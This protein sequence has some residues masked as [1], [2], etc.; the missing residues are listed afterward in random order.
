[1]SHIDSIYSFGKRLEPHWLAL[2]E[3]IKTQLFSTDTPHFK[4]TGGL[5]T[6]GRQPNLTDRLNDAIARADSTLFSRFL[7][8]NKAG[9]THAPSLHDSTVIFTDGILPTK[10]DP[11]FLFPLLKALDIPYPS[12]APAWWASTKGCERAFHEP[13]SPLHKL[14]DAAIL[15]AQLNP[16]AWNNIILW[17]VAPVAFPTRINTSGAEYAFPQALASIDAACEGRIS[18]GSMH[19]SIDD[20]NPFSTSPP[21][22]GTFECNPLTY[23]AQALLDLLAQNEMSFD[24]RLEQLIEQGRNRTEAVRYLQEEIPYDAFLKKE[25]SAWYYAS[26]IDKLG[27]PP[28]LFAPKGSSTY[29]IMKRALKLHT[30]KQNIPAK[31]AKHRP[32]RRLNLIGYEDCGPLD[33]SKKSIHGILE[34][35][36]LDALN[37]YVVNKHFARTGKTPRIHANVLNKE[38]I[39]F[40]LQPCPYAPVWCEAVY[41]QTCA[42]DSGETT[43]C[44]RDLFDAMRDPTFFEEAGLGP[45]WIEAYNKQHPPINNIAELV[46]RRCK[47]HQFLFYSAEH[48][49]WLLNRAEEFEVY[50]SADFVDRSKLREDDSRRRKGRL[51]WQYEKG[52][53]VIF[54]LIHEPYPPESAFCRISALGVSC[55]IARTLTMRPDAPPHMHASV[56]AAFGTAGHF[57]M[58]GTTREELMLQELLWSSLGMEPLSRAEYTEHAITLETNGTHWSGHSDCPLLKGPEPLPPHELPGKTLDLVIVDYKTSV[59]TFS[60]RK[61]YILQLGAYALSYAQRHPETRFKNFYLAV[62]NRPFISE[63][64]HGPFTQKITI[65]K[66]ENKPSDLLYEELQHELTRTVEEQQRLRNS[67]YFIQYKTEQ[68]RKGRCEEQALTSKMGCYPDQRAKC[69][70][71]HEQ[72][73]EYP[74]ANL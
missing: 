70:C 30:N 67:E 73:K 3:L 41:D 40:N 54:P 57:L 33:P 56:A 72:I 17:P 49:A 61:K 2:G 65:V 9:L 31:L 18:I 63:H 60:P 34:A 7:E 62:V 39:Q 68:A 20:A 6:T 48:I 13:Y 32:P 12:Y 26:I 64:M 23:D 71:L 74:T 22:I 10:L 8:F 58:N 4:H 28:V 59:K 19:K 66:I 29:A 69:N 36:A 42:R 5:R 52:N 35:S 55:D 25:L 24:T 27:K 43:Y 51:S 47:E 1:M 21:K 50:T 11:A 38:D 46:E 15:M 37:G 45:A 16:D 53:D 44:T 14:T